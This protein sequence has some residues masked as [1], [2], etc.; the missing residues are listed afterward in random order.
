[1]CILNSLNVHV[2]FRFIL[3]LFSFPG[4]T[5]GNDPDGSG[6]PVKGII[7]SGTVKRNGRIQI[8]DRIMQI[9]N[10]NLKNATI[11]EARAALK[12]A[13]QQDQVM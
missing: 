1:M 5:L 4:I 2:K 13:S 9:G 6:C 3:L 10:D 12:K 7:E 8:N 11:Q